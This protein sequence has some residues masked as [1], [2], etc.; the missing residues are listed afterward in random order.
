MEPN[1]FEGDYLIINEWGY[2]KTNIGFFGFNTGFSVNPF[3]EV[4][5]LSVVVVRSPESIRSNAT[6]FIKRVIGLPGETVSIEDG[7]VRISNTEHPE[8][9]ILDESTYL[10]P[11]VKTSGTGITLKEDEYFIMGDNRGNSSDSRSWGALKKDHMVGKVFFRI[12]PVSRFRL[13]SSAYAG[14]TS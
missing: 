9:F 1:F 8:G 6:Y 4:D 5:R 13:F 7:H 3:K 11:L 12:L 14:I 10:S 2:K